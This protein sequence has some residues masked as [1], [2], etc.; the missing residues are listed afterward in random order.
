MVRCVR[1]CGATSAAAGNA[2]CGGSDTD[3]SDPMILRLDE[4]VTLRPRTIGTQSGAIAHHGGLGQ[5]FQFGPEEA[6]VV[7][8][9][10]GRRGMTE[11]TAAIHDAGMDW[12]PEEI[13]EFLSMLVRGHVL[14]ASGDPASGRPDGRDAGEGGAGDADAPVRDDPLLRQEAS[15]AQAARTRLWLGSLSWV[16]SLR[17]PIMNFDGVAR[18]LVGHVGWLFTP[19][20]VLLWSMLVGS[21][22]V[23]MLSSQD[24]FKTDLRRI[25]D[26]SMWMP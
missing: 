17:F 3:M 14:I 25:F 15:L 18:R 20:G 7:G 16:I 4:T 5:Y 21:S 10:D 8:L 23:L 12:T 9:I 19:V 11:L 13:S 6:F 26:A 22:F 2:C 24:A 1:W